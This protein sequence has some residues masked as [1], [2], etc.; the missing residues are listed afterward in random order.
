MKRIS[1]F[2][3]TALL[4]LGS[5][6]CNREKP[7]YPFNDPSLSV[8]K[9][10]NDLLGRLTIEEKV[11]MMM[12][13]SIAVERLGIPA[14]NWWNE[15]LHGVARAGDATVFP[16]VIGIAATFDE[17]L[18]LE[19][20]TI[21]SD[22]ARAK[23]N[24]AIA[25][26]TYRQYYGLT[27]WT[28]NVNIF[29]D[30]RWGRGHE[31][32]GEDPYLTSRMGLAAVRGLQGNDR[33]F[34]KANAC[35]KHY[36]V[37]SGPEPNR[38]SFD[39]TVSPTDLWETYLPAF[40]TLVTEGNVQEVMCAYNRYEGDPCC[41]STKLLIDILRNRWNYEGIVVSD[42][43]AIDDFYVTG[44][45]ETHPDALTASKDAILS[46]TDL[47][48]GSSF[49]SMI[50][51]AEKGIITDAD[52]DPH[53]GR[54]IA[55]RIELGMLDPVDLTP[56]KDY[57]I[58]DICTPAH[59]A[60]SL[61]VA[62]ESMVLLKNEG[63][64]L[65]LSKNLKKIAVVGVNA[66]DSA[67]LLGN[68]NGTPRSVVTILDGIK[69]KFSNADVTYVEG[70]KL[71]DGYVERVRNSADTRQRRTPQFYEGIVEGSAP[72]A[73][74]IVPP[75]PWFAPENY[76]E[77]VAQIKDAEVIIYVG[78]L[79]P[80]LEGEEMRG[81]SYEGFKGGD[82]TV[83]EL[84]EVQSRLLAALRSTG[85][86]VVF[87]LTT[88]STIGLEKDEPSYD[89]LLVAWYPGE[90]GGN[91]VADVLAGDYNP[92]G[93]LPLTFYK[94]TEQLPDFEDYD[95][96]GRTY[97]YFE[98][99]PLYPFGYGIGYTSFSYGK[100]KLSSSSI[101]KGKSVKVSFD[102]RNDGGKDGEEVAQVYVR[103]L[104]DPAAPLKSL[105]GFKRAAIKAGSSH[106]FEFTLGPDAFSFYDQSKDDLAVKAGE[107]EILFGG[108]SDDS[109]LQKLTLTV[110]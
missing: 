101:R 78:G 57:D 47:E 35:A 24:D 95:M 53:V 10:V 96:T 100:G 84:P 45:H 90:Q 83:I 93:R 98:G 87:V 7:E 82:R 30:P 17:D 68:Y 15:A 67:M 92:A 27:F 54:L 9:R 60:H 12:N 50:E 26:G 42:C 79:S 76:D 4:C 31:T 25:N 8:E 77:V 80:N 109:N 18:N 46:G 70:S 6:S 38:H 94:S 104:G 59:I 97:R 19:T 36:A 103:R 91:A 73:P 29:R 106:K 61:K 55:D 85:K 56:W 64:V 32:Y 28:P 11:G 37:H 63:N 108:S 88:G 71:V 43:G 39:V 40:K 34:F 13:N 81:V 23:Y 65:P 21:A 66:A 72:A 14:Y 1:I 44:R 5:V 49:R 74:V 3:F 20:Y 110:K 58:D 69:A 22:E 2:L 16:Q 75:Q 62:R 33:K 51:G 107:Y 86:P 48:C 105:R 89:A 52:L 99:E 102:V 41:G